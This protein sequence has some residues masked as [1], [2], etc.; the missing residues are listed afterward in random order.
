MI[1]YWSPK[2]YQ[3]SKDE[4]HFA[5]KMA[6]DL[7]TFMKAKAHV[8]A[9]AISNDGNKFA[10]FS[11]DDKVRVFRFLDGKLSRAYDEA[12]QS[13]QDLQRAGSGESSNG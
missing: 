3:L 2:D 6:T 12:L 5:S 7:Y 8:F 4:R 13:V 9:L 1:E 10:T 11:S